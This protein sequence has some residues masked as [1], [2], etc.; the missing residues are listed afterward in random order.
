MTNN[1]SMEKPENFWTGERV[2]L[3]TV[4]EGLVAFYDSVKIVG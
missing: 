3:S 2:S 4:L 1:S